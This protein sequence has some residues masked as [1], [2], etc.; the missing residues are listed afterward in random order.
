VFLVREPTKESYIITSI[1]IV[2]LIYMLRV[3]YNLVKYPHIKLQG[4]EIVSAPGVILPSQT[5]NLSESFHVSEHRG[6]IGVRQGR[7]CV[8]VVYSV[9]P[10]NQHL[11]LRQFLINHEFNM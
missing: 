3:L 4:N 2:V 8:S 7:K 10:E 9:L 6:N 1:M 11:E 5:I